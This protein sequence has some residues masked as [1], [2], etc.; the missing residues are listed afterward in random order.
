MMKPHVRILA[1]C[2]T[3]PSL[4]RVQHGH[5]ALLEAGRGGDYH[6]GA[7]AARDGGGHDVVV[8]G[9]ASRQVERGHVRRDVLLVSLIFKVC[10]MQWNWKL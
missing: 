2:W 3:C 5:D 10:I 8:G 7:P 6:L 9:G 1:I 4:I